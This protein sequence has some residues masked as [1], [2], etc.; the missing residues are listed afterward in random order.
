MSTDQLINEVVR[1]LWAILLMVRDSFWTI[2]CNLWAIPL[3]E[4]IQIVGLVIVV[5]ALMARRKLFVSQLLHSRYQMFFSSWAIDN[6]DVRQFRSKPDLF[7]E[8]MDSFTLRNYLRDDN[9]IR[10]YLLIV[11]LYEY[12]AFAHALTFSTKYLGRW[13]TGKWWEK[14]RNKYVDRRLMPKYWERSPNRINDNYFDPY[15][16]Q[17]VER[18]VDILMEDPNFLDVHLSY[19]DD[20]PEFYRFINDTHPEFYNN[21]VKDR[22]KQEEKGT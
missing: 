5:L 16:E 9:A 3:G 15:G 6:E 20:H 12:F 13:R 18:W 7:V 14:C 10:N 19:Q 22:E 1:Q 17:W 2:L 8:N 11:Q 4:K 21:F